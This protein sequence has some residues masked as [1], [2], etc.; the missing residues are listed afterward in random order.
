MS[1]C[2]LFDADS[3]GDLDLYC[4]SGSSEFGRNT[5]LYQDRLY[6][7]NGD[8]KFTFDETAL[9]KIESSGSCVIAAD[10]DK[11][12]DL[13]MFVGGRVVPMSY[14]VSPRSYLLQNDGSGKFE[15]VTSTLS[16]GL[17][18]VGMVTDALFTDF[19]N[20]GWEDLIVVGEWMPITLF[21]NNK[22]RFT[23]FKELK[24]GWWNSIAGADF[25]GDGDTDYIAGNLGKNS[26]LQVN[27][28]EPVSL[29]AKDFDGNGSMD[30]I[31]TR[32]P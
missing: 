11:D 9:P 22:G 4:V 1:V 3:D 27:E 10:F 2:C 32:L 24:T 29:Y 20:D 7:N 30:P 23:K 13:D 17:D 14:P 21:K 31:I 5:A 16:V 25:D 26:V 19:D 28:N 18:S 6:R 15:D 12:N 8:G